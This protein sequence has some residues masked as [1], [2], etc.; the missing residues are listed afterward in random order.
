V[1]A[2]RAPWEAKKSTHAFR[3]TTRTSSYLIPTVGDM[4]LLKLVVFQ[5][6]VMWVGRE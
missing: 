4:Q 5:H 2:S 6:K 1:K 3:D